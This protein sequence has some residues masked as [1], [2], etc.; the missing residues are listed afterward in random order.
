MVITNNSTREAV[1]ESATSDIAQ[2]VEL[3]EMS[4]MNGMMNMAMVPNIPIPAHDK[5][6]LQ[7]GGFHI[8]M[9]GL[10][11]PVNK[12]DIVLITLHFKD[13]S[14]VPVNAQARL[15]EKEDA[16]SMAGMKM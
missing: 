9:I 13:G 11:K 7:P 1:L 5:V 8:M 15:E 2:S 10:K 3:H 16:S 12:G 4:D 6:S 14:V